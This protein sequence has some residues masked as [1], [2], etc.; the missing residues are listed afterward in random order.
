MSVLRGI[1]IV[2][3]CFVILIGISLFV[4]GV[5]R[6]FKTIAIRCLQCL[7]P[8]P[9][10]R[11]IAIVTG[12]SRGLGKALK[13]QLE[14]IGY[15]VIGCCR[16]ATE[17][18][19]NSATVPLDLADSDSINYF[20]DAL[21]NRYGSNR[22]SLLINNAAIVT[23][24]K[25]ID[26]D[27]LVDDQNLREKLNKERMTEMQS[28]FLT[29]STAVYV[30]T[31][32]LYDASVLKRGSLVLNISSTNGCLNYLNSNSENSPDYYSVSKA[33]LN[34][35]T[36]V[37]NSV[38]HPSIRVYSVHPGLIRTTVHRSTDT[39]A[40]LEPEQVAK[41]LC[42]TFV[43]PKEDILSSKNNFKVSDFLDRFGNPLPW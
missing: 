37:L 12:A 18:Q 32:A 36:G 35:V 19:D 14:Q 40:M 25:Q 9:K 13:L 28:A 15:T 27:S 10:G 11:P 3:F 31:R 30:F 17:A 39:R 5:R 29:N 24:S 20:V 33:A 4:N 41:D 16:T 22:V 21:L 2:F 8:A 1:L 26:H 6:T 23:K 42:E 38:L 7:P 34:A 43:I